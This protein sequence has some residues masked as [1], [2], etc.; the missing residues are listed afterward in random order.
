MSEILHIPRWEAGYGEKAVRKETFKVSEVVVEKWGLVEHTSRILRG[1]SAVGDITFPPPI[2]LFRS[3]LPLLSTFTQSCLLVF[4]CSYGGVIS[5]GGWSVFL[6]SVV[7]ENRL[8]LLISNRKNGGRQEPFIYLVPKPPFCVYPLPLF[9]PSC[10]YGDS[11]TA[12]VKIQ[13]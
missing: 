3:C 5:D 6:E 4:S 11:I 12:P 1:L 2:S 8:C 10:F 9:F 7:L 13:S